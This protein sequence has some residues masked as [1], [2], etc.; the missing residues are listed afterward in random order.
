MGVAG[1]RVV[2]FAGFAVALGACSST[3]NLLSGSPLDLFSSSSKATKTDTATGGEETVTASDIECPDLKV[4]TGA[5]TLMIGSKP[6]E[7]EPAALD[8]RYQGTI[9][10][11]ARECNV[12]AGMMTMK[13]GIEG[14]VITGPAGGPGTVDVPLRIAVVQEGLTPKPIVSK[15]G[16]EQVTIA[17]AVDRVTFTHIESDLTFPLPQP[18]GLID[19]Y[20]V[21]VGFDPLGAKPEPKRPVRRK[22]KQS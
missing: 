4:R 8:V 13:V 7:G 1:L 16:R 10:R 9:V 12:H 19:S 3:S 2:A 15:F 18:L 22:P 5:S 6:G 17:N 11:L 21:Y 20:T 14:R